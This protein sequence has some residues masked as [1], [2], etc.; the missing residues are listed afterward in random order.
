MT[1]VEWFWYQIN[2]MDYCELY[3]ILM[4]IYEW[5]PIFFILVPNQWPLKYVII[6]RHKNHSVLLEEWPV[7]VV[8]WV[9]NNDNKIAVQQI[10]H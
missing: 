4:D 9:H 2:Q 7:V 5:C 8:E 10:V 1:T 6:V 3:G